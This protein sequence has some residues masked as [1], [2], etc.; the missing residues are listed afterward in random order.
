MPRRKL[1]ITEKLSKLEQERKLILESRTN[2][3][4][5]LFTAFAGLE[6][7]NGVSAG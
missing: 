3:I 7:V 2:E 1:A 5:G 4:T 6:I